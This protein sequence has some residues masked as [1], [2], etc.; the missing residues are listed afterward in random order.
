MFKTPIGA[1]VR[2]DCSIE[3]EGIE[4]LKQKLDL[5]GIHDLHVISRQFASDI[6]ALAAAENFHKDLGI[7]EAYTFHHEFAPAHYLVDRS[8]DDMVEY[9]EDGTVESIGGFHNPFEMI[10]IPIHNASSEQVGL[11]TILMDSFQI[12]Q[13]MTDIIHETVHVH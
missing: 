3:V 8:L 13:S 9:S 6:E 1:T 10:S 11:T 4:A 12:S 5:L 7:H 2:Y